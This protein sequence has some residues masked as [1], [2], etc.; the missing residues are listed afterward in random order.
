MGI[1]ASDFLHRTIT[2]CRLR[3]RSDTG[4]DGVMIQIHLLLN[5]F[6]LKVHVCLRCFPVEN[7]VFYMAAY[8]CVKG[9]VREA[10]T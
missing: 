5:L 1:S 9:L 8:M 2:P 7:R 4:G 6:K 10:V 3:G